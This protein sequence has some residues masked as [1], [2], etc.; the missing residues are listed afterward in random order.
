[1]RLS[2]PLLLGLFIALNTPTLRGD[3]TVT[4]GGA[5]VPV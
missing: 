3:E 1:M 2:F 5:V 4:V